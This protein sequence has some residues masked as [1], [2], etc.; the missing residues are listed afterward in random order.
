M[1]SENL[2]QTQGSELIYGI[3]DKP[4]LRLAIPLAIQHIMAAFS[5]IVAVPLVV[6]QAIGLSVEDMAF[7]VSA[8]LF[9]AGIATFIQVYGIGKAGSRLPC[10]MGTEFTFVGRYCRGKCFWIARIF[11]S[12][13]GRLIFRDNPK[14]FYKTIEKVFPTSSY[15]SSS[16]TNRAYDV[17]CSCGLVCWWSWKSRVW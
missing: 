14:S 16:F 1:S 4:P 12:Y 15:R 17:T 2:E 9:V 8:T 6:G 7:M 5:G 10:M 3:D 13:F 11:W